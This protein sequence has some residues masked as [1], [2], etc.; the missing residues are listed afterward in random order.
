MEKKK[1]LVVDDDRTLA[2]TTAE[3]LRTNGY[4][5]ALAYDS[6]QAITNAFNAPPNLILLDIKMPAGGGMNAYASLRSSYKTMDI[7]I[8]F[9]S[10]VSKEEF[11]DSVSP[12][13]AK[14]FVGKP[15][16]MDEL[17]QK[18]KTLIG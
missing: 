14:N 18:I 13:D 15:Y 2:Q 4:E 11:V 8:I 9:T 6:Y 17:L 12:K 5:V 3:I 16:N 7:P 10:G 1:V